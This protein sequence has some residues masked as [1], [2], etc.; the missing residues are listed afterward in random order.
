MPAITAALIGGGTSLAAG[1][2]GYKGAQKGASGMED[3]AEVMWAQLQEQKRIA[4]KQ[5][6]IS[7]PFRDILYPQIKKYLRNP[8]SITRGPLYGAYISPLAQQ[9]NV[10]R[11]ELEERSPRGGALTSA[12]ANLYQE[13]GRARAG[14]MADLYNN[15]SNIG[16]D[17]GRF[18][19]QPGMM[20]AQSG[21]NAAS[22][23]MPS[24]SNLYS[25]GMQNVGAAGYGLG[26]TLYDYYMGGGSGGSGGGSGML[27]GSNPEFFNKFTLTP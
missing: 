21:M 8:S 17:I 22:S 20:A 9:F 1:Y 24:Y 16:L 13:G 14:V 18:N 27:Y 6:K 15:Y 5:E 25:A 12:L 2:M 7:H 26:S 23:M 11:N 3:M 10:A 4:A 19:T